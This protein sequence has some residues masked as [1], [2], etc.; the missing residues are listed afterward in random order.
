MIKNKWFHAKVLPKRFHLN[1]HTT[2]F[3]PQTQKLDVVIIDHDSVS[4]RGHSLIPCLAD[5]PIQLR[6]GDCDYFFVSSQVSNC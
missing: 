6:R 5:A 2:G 3:H 4:E 1:S